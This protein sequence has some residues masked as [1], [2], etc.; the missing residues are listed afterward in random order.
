MGS[1][2]CWGVLTKGYELTSVVYVAKCVQATIMH[3]DRCCGVVVFG[4]V[5][6]FTV[7]LQ[8]LGCLG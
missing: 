1:V 4:F 6:L 2:K 8:M 3:A 7:C 5:D